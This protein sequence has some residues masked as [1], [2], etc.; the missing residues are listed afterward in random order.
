MAQQVADKL[1]KE[2]LGEVRVID[3]RTL[4]PYDWNTISR[5]VKETGRILFVNEDTEITNFGEHLMRRVIEDHF[6]ELRARPRVLAAKHVPGVGLAPTLE[7][8]TVPQ[9]S[10]I[11]RELRAL[12]TEA[13]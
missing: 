7:E 1:S 10:D 3:L 6:Y 4:Y 5:S 9:S 12:L 8:A 11:E 13:T 2:G